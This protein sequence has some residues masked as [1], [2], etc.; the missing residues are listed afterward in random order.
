MDLPARLFDLPHPGV[1]PPLD[2][3]W[4]DEQERQEVKKKITNVK[5]TL[6]MTTPVWRHAPPPLNVQKIF[7][8]R[9]RVA[10]VIICFKCYRHQ[11]SGFLAAR[12]QNGDFPLTLT[13]ALTK[14]TTSQ[15]SQHYS[16]ACD[17]VHTLL[18]Y[19]QLL[20]CNGTQGNT[21]LP[22]PIYGSKRSPPQI[23]IMI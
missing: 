6:Q 18:L 1:A 19:E 4:T 13:V 16:A 7:G 5:K 10:D 20:K 12:C 3:I 9:S 21:V 22:P 14:V 15:H 17:R 8:I 2:A 11:L 23:V